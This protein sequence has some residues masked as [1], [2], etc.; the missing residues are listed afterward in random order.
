MKLALATRLGASVKVNARNVEPV[1]FLK[2]KIGGAHGALVT[3]VS[4]RA[5]EQAVGM[6]RRGGTVS[7]NGRPPDEFP[8]DISGTVL[9]GVTVRGSIVGSCLEL[10]ESLECAEQRKV[11]ATVHTDHVEKINN[12]FTRRHKGWIAGRM[13]LDIAA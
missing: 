10:Q 11:A 1:A 9:N 7:H 6:V 12:R 2:K 8:L 4:P 5:F 13:V 3:A